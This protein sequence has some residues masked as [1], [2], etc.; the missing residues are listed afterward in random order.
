MST[1]EDNIKKEFEEAEGITPEVQTTKVNQEGT[2]TE[3]GKVDVT[4]GLGIISPDDPEIR[5]IN[6]AAGY[7]S[8]DLTELPSKGR[9]YRNDF[10]LSLRAARVG[11]IRDFSTI[12]ENN[13][14]DVD[15]KLNAI[16]VSCARVM[17]GNTRGSYKDIL[18]ED[19]IY[20]I[21]KIKELTFK[22]GENKLMM[23]VKERKC[24]SGVCESQESVELRT[25]NLQFH[26]EDELL[27]K[28]YD[29]E[30]RCYVIST[31]SHGQIIMAPPSI[32]VMR[33]ITDYI[34][35]R[36]E[37]GLKWDESSLQILPYVKREW[38]G[39]T[40]KEIFAAVTEFQGWNSGKFSIVYRLAEKMRLGVKPELNYPCQGCGAEVTVPL[41]FPGGVKALF[42]I[43][44]ISSEL[45]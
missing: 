18:E 7:I 37:D 20:V 33:A 30:S 34:R 42:V 10:K 41:T 19:R 2:V 26:E 28:Y 29:E 16:L 43:S 9:F 4:R 39:F 22:D 32:G 14:K 11:E 35:K 25:D 6:E 31:K 5:R 23:P 27:G 17:Y 1:H 44:D 3:L 21:L 8:L 36:E 12:D 45:L 13:I 15:E 24:S 40:D 38:R